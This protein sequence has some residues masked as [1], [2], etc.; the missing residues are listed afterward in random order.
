M[1][2]GEA[3]TID[4][5]KDEIYIIFAN[6]APPLN[7]AMPQQARAVQENNERLFF[8]KANINIRGCQNITITLHQRAEFERHQYAKASESHV[9]KA[10]RGMAPANHWYPRAGLVPYFL[11]ER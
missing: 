8:A 11:F 2:V 1:T 9:S 5:G 6:E 10:G 7:N 4:G 3:R